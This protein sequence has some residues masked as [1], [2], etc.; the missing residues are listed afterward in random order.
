MTRTRGPAASGA[1][2]TERAIKVV[3]FDLDNTLWDVE[4]VLLRAEQ[5]QYQW[6]S[7]H[8]PRVTGEFDATE[9]RGLRMLT[10]KAH[11]ELAHH[12]SDLRRQALYDVQLHAGYSEAEA[13]AGATE[14]FD[15]FLAVRHQVEP[16]EQAL[17]VLEQL[18]E[19]YALGALTNGNADIFKVDIGEYFDFAFSAEELGASKPLPDMFHAG[20]RASGAAGHQMVHVGDNP[21]HDIQGARE[22]GMYTVWM[23]IAG[24]DWIDAA[25]ADEE[26]RSLDQLPAAIARIDQ[27]ARQTADRRAP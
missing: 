11:P 13:R 19:D 24:D 27:R 17:E 22:V 26:V 15:V 4:P 14:A 9:L 25:P 18:A 23:N 1:R 20:M 6:L 16:Y 10:F 12:I 21:E 3:T 7:E 8:R 5:A 2:M